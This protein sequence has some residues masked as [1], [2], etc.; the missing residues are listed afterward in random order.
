MEASEIKKEILF[1]HHHPECEDS[2]ECATYDYLEALSPKHWVHVARE[3]L[4]LLEEATGRPMPDEELP[5][6]VLNA[7][8][9]QSFY[10]A[11]N[12]IANALGLDK[13]SLASA[14]DETYGR[15]S[16]CTEPMTFEQFKDEVE[17]F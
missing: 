9:A 3:G 8:A 7:V 6:A 16:N 2:I 13:E 14:V 10:S 1:L 12:I 4:R 11:L 17:S 15:L 5:L